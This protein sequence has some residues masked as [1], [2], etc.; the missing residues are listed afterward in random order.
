VTPTPIKLPT[1]DRYRVF[2][3]GGWTTPVALWV[4]ATCRVLGRAR[5]RRQPPRFSLRAAV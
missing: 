2:R 1:D 5:V 4:R 3:G